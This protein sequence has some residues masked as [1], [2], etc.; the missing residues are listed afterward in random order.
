MAL[1]RYLAF[2]CL[3]GW[4]LLLFAATARAQEDD[5]QMIPTPANGPPPAAAEPDIR[6]MHC[7]PDVKEVE[8][9]RAI[10]IACTLDYPVAGVEFRYRMQASGSKKWDKIELQK[11]DNGYAGT[12]PCTVTGKVGTLEFYLFARNDEN[13]VIARIGRHERPLS[14]RLVEQSSAPPPALPG[15]QAAPRCYEQNECPPDL[16]GTA[17]CPGTHVPKKEKKTW[18]ASCGSTSEC[19]T[20]LEC[21][22]G[23]CETPAKCDDAKDCSEGGECVD[24]VCHIPTPEELKGKMGP[25]KH[26]WIG[27]HAGVDFYMMR[28]AT[29][30]CGSDTNDSKDFACFEGGNEYT[31]TPNVSYAGH[32]KSSLYFATVRAMLSYEYAFGRL[33]VGG[34]LGW[35]FRGAPKDFSPIHI[36]A[37]VHYSLVKKP[38]DEHFRPYLGLAFGHAQ[39]DA[40]GATVIVDCVSHDAATNSACRSATNKNDIINNLKDPTIAVQ[41]Q[42]N[43]YRSGAPFFFGPSIQ[44]MYA[45]TNESAFI[46]N[47]TAMLPDVTFE[48]SIGYQMGL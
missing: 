39:V 20:G 7:T 35:A 47:F 3:I 36:E 25:A 44:L 14:I 41:R 21:L 26:H 1:L 18:G 28:E 9:R 40:S 33:L 4:T 11:T 48:P 19:Q 15:Q 32:I 29:G 22:K 31:G 34:R 13:K 27:L 2:S 10:P 38:F 43:A 46:F 12:I 17:A 30:V 42:L 24:G 8:T 45:I 6:G 23:S 16:L 37:R 5:I